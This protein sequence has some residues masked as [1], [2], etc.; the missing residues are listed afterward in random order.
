VTHQHRRLGRTRSMQMGSEHP[1][2]STGGGTWVWGGPINRGS[3]LSY[4]RRTGAQPE[5]HRARI[6]GA[7]R[8]LQAP[9]PIPKLAKVGVADSEGCGGGG[10]RSP[11]LNKPK[12]AECGG[13]VARAHVYA[14][15]TRVPPNTA[16]YPDG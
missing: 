8:P 16:S 13:V 5:R 1:P 11:C 7:A 3:A 6:G 2:A 12:D 4:I 14:R 9:P 10:Y 15:E